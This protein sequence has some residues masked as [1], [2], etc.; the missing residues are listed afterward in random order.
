MPQGDGAMTWQ[1]SLRGTEGHQRTKSYMLNKLVHIS[2]PIGYLK[3]DC[4]LI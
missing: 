3:V 1:S 4:M 2:I